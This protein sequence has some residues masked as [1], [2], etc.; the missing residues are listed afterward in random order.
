MN[1]FWEVLNATVKLFLELIWDNFSLKGSK[2]ATNT[3]F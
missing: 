3:Y 1:I 2:Y